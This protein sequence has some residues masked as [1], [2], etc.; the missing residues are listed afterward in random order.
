MATWWKEPTHW[1]RPWCWERLRAEGEVGDRGWDGWTP[2]LTRWTWVWANS[3]RRWRTRKP[4]VPQSMGLQRIRLDLVK[5]SEVK[6]AQLCL[7]L[8]DPMDCTVHGILQ[9]RILEWVAF[10]FSRDL[11]NPGIEPRSPALQADSLPAESQ[12]KTLKWTTTANLSLLI[13]RCIKCLEKQIQ[14]SAL[15][16]QH[17]NNTQAWWN[18]FKVRWT[19]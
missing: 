5:W 3:G 18:H 15:G 2:S 11:L 17:Y 16:Y 7:T 6:V 10:L 1:K 9:T 19:F 13:T 4:R 14:G 8:C 12:G